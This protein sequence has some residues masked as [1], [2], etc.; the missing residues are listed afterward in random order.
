MKHKGNHATVM[1]SLVRGHQGRQRTRFWLKQAMVIQNAYRRHLV[2]SYLHMVE[3]KLFGKNGIVEAWR[4]SKV[5]KAQ[6]KRWTATQRI[7]KVFVDT[8]REPGM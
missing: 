6:R 1:Q 5:R 8:S 7:Q 4:A 2:S 3:Q